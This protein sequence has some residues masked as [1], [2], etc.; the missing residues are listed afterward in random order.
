MYAFIFSSFYQAEEPL[1]TFQ[2]SQE[3]LRIGILV[4]HVDKRVEMLYIIFGRIPQIQ[5]SK[6]GSVKIDVYG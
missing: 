2:G 1:S 3:W 6:K 4:S 5:K